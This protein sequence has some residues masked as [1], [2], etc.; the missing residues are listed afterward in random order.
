MLRKLNPLK[1]HVYGNGASNRIEDADMVIIEDYWQIGRILD[2]F[3]EKLSAKDIKF[4]EDMQG[5]ATGRVED[6]KYGE[7]GDPLNHFLFGEY[8]D[9]FTT[10]DDMNPCFTDGTTFSQLPYDINGNIRVL[11]VYWKS[12]EESKKLNFMTL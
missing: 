12:L 11:Q 8:S 1:V 4:L 10:D 9:G 2:T 5:Q 7:Y 6:S 3:H